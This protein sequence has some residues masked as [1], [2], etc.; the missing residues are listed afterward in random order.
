[1]TV[2]LLPRNTV[3]QKAK[4]YVTFYYETSKTAP[5]C[6]GVTAG[7]FDG[8]GMSW[9]I[10]QFNWKS[11][12]I[13]PIFKDLINN[14]PTVCLNA[15]NNDQA[16]Y[17]EWVDVVFNKTTTEQ[18]AWGTSKTIYTQFNADGTPVRSSGR[19]LQAPWQT[20]FEQLGVTPESIARQDVAVQPYLDNGE[21]W[22]KKFS[23]WSRRGFLLLFDIAVQSGGINAY[24]SD[25]SLRVD[26]EA[27]I[28][29]DI[30]ALSPTLSKNDREIAIMRS[31]ANRKADT[32]STEWQQSYRDRKLAIAN[33][34]GMVYG[35]PTDTVPYDM[36]LEPAFDYDVDY[37][38]FPAIRYIRDWLNGSNENA[39]NY[40]NE[41]RVLNVNGVNL[42][43]GKSVTSNAT[44]TNAVNITDNNVSTYAYET[45]NTGAKYV[46]LDLGATYTDIKSIEVFHY[47]AT[48]IRTFQGTKVEVSADG[49]I[50][51]TLRDSA[52]S[53]TYLETSAGITL[54][55]NTYPTIVTP[56]DPSALFPPM[57]FVRDWLNGNSVNPNNYW[58]DI[59]VMAGGVNIAL[60]LPVTSNS[61]VNN[62]A[63]ITDGNNTT[64]GYIFS[65]V[66]DVPDYVQID[67]GA[68]RSDVES[69]G[70]THFFGDNRT[71]YGTRTE[72]SED[73]VN[74]I[75]LF[76]SEF[77]GI[78]QETSQGKTYF[79]TDIPSNEDIPKVAITG[80]SFPKVSHEE[81]FESTNLTFKFSIDTDSYTVRCGGNSPTTGIDCQTG[82]RDVKTQALNYTV[83]SSSTVKVSEFRSIKANTEIT[84]N[85]HYS[86]L[87]SEGDNKINIYGRNFDGIWTP[88]Q[89]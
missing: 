16:R 45:S 7:D 4:D 87:L 10:I 51:H 30:Q 50:W 14:Y 21:N 39:Y 3:Y 59:K 23:L 76:N 54:K 74:W 20:Y 27:Q 72:F 31:I 79:P 84:A 28:F 86:E 40:W 70:V 53:G 22:K 57:R 77:E 80:I 24:N 52:I 11:T 25:G 49:N 85:I 88:F 44:L 73:G 18:I 78:Y 38:P 62:P 37:P 75:T 66:G 60:G 69:I 81:G 33:G 65:T 26:V 9:G 32:V 6:Y 68:V 67:L 63:N 15:F 12:T 82:S 64:Y 29:S 13:Q 48:G 43:Q 5:D 17:N 56:V 46:Q 41:I 34:S 61:T 89:T 35:L 71:F 47:Y 19:K 1:M 55:S 83:L 2:G 42:A 8:A 58:N 36:I